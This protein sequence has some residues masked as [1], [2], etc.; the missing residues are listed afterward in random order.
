MLKKLRSAEP[1]DTSRVAQASE[2]ESLVNPQQPPR[3]R[4]RLR[5]TSD[6][7]R[8][9][10]ETFRDSPSPPRTSNSALP[11]DRPRMPT[12]N[13]NPDIDS[14]FNNRTEDI[15]HGVNTVLGSDSAFMRAA[16]SSSVEVQ[17]TAGNIAAI[18]VQQDSSLVEPPGM[19]ENIIQLFIAGHNMANEMRAQ[20]RQQIRN[21]RAGGTR[22]PSQIPTAFQQMIALSQGRLMEP[23][24]QAPV[25]NPDPLGLSRTPVF[26]LDQPWSHYRL[27]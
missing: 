7:G 18:A 4:A 8:P 3:L 21:D 27:K 15:K 17:P 26:L 13:I 19:T 11:T 25:H 5:I 22:T 16:R 1:S 9:L 20:H 12:V 2:K 14:I 10:H 23:P 24:S 6:L